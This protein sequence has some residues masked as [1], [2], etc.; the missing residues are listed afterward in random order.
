MVDLVGQKPEKMRYTEGSLRLALLPELVHKLLGIHF[1]QFPENFDLDETGL[2]QVRTRTGNVPLLE[3]AQIKGLSGMTCVLPA[4]AI[5]DV[6][7]MPK[8]KDE[9]DKKN[10]ALSARLERED[11]VPRCLE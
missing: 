5:L 8:L 3:G 7:N 9:R 4:W 11:K 10:E 6:L 1:A 2:S